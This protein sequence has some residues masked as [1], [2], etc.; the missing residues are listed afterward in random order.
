VPRWLTN[1]LTGWCVNQ[2]ENDSKSSLR[3]AQSIADWLNAPPDSISPNADLSK[4]PIQ[5]WWGNDILKMCHSADLA[6]AYRR[7]IVQAKN[8]LPRL[9]DFYEAE[10][11]KGAS[12]TILLLQV[13]SDF[14][15]VH[16]SRALISDIG[17]DV[18][19]RFLSELRGG[20]AQ[21]L[22]SHFAAAVERREPIYLRYVQG[23]SDRYVYWEQ[24]ALP[25]TAD[26][27]LGKT[28]F[29]LGY[30][31]PI[32]DKIDILKVIFE[33]LPIGMIAAAAELGGEPDDAKL[34]LINSSAKRMLKFPTAGQPVFTVRDLAL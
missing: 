19:G 6:E 2:I 11:D 23:V 32:D 30:P 4:A 24:V 25:M 18:R 15:H 20:V 27:S 10:P 31:A 12:E 33:H 34:L 5:A 21:D 29:L 13:R 22:I 3:V 28:T 17:R 14:L 1:Y 16:Q 8:G 7:W 26:E 9:K